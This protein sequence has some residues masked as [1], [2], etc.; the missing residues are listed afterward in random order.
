MNFTNE[1]FIFTSSVLKCPHCSRYVPISTSSMVMFHTDCGIMGA[2]KLLFDTQADL[3]I[4]FS[5][6][7]ASVVFDELQFQN[8]TMYAFLETHDKQ[9]A[10]ELLEYY[11]HKTNIPTLKQRTMLSQQMI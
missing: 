7:L 8:A 11:I 3:H 2:Y 4:L 9:I 5:R 10:L 1:L 6:R